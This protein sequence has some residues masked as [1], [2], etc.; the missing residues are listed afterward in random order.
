LAE[1]MMKS[2]FRLLVVSIF[3][4]LWTSPSPAQFGSLPI[5]NC[6]DYASRALSQVQIA[7]GCGFTGPRWSSEVPAHEN[8]CKRA[9]TRDRSREYNERLKAL[10]GCRGDGGAV[11][12]ANCNEYAARFRSQLDLAKA[13]GSSCSFQGMRWSENLVQHMHWCNRTS[14]N[15]H[16]FEDAARRRELAE[17]KAP[18]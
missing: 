16:E 8:W 6:D 4:L 18:K 12:V 11:P 17:C 1:T 14:A 2:T 10:I 9:S 15:R 3:P 5:E 13:L 7:T